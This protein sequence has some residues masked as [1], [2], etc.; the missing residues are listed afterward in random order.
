METV[1]ERWNIFMGIGVSIIRGSPGEE[2]R[3]S[4]KSNLKLPDA[5]ALRFSS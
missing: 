4:V 3:V 5:A 1:R 2:Q